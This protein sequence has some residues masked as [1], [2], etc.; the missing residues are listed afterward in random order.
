ME[1]S[2]SAVRRGSTAALAFSAAAPYPSIICNNGQ[3]C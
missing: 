1:K 3:R 2:I